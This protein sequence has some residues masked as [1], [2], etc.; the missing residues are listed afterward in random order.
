MRNS[1]YIKQSSNTLR[2]VYLPSFDIL[3]VFLPGISYRVE[4][5]DDSAQRDKVGYWIGGIVYNG[6]R[7]GGMYVTDGWWVIDGLD[8]H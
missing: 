6:T 8:R 1:L 4:R 7:W 5:K 2:L 3:F